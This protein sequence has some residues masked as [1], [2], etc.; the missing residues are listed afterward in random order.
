MKLLRIIIILALSLFCL[1]FCMCPAK[2]PYTNPTNKYIIALNPTDKYIDAVTDLDKIKR[3]IDKGEDM[4]ALDKG[5]GLAPLHAIV[6]FVNKNTIFA[7]QDLEN[8][9]KDE[10]DKKKDIVERYYHAA[11]LLLDNGANVNVTDKHGS[12][13]LNYCKDIRCAKFFLKYGAD[14]NI[15][16]PFHDATCS[17]A[18]DL[19]KLY[20]ASGADVNARS[21]EGRTLLFC[22]VGGKVTEI[23][24]KNGADVKVKDINGE[25]PLF[26]WKNS[27][28]AIELMIKNGADV[29]AKN[30]KGETALFQPFLKPERVRLFVKYKINVNEQDNT[31]KTVLHHILS[32]EYPYPCDKLVLELLKNGAKVDIKDKVGKTSLD[33]ASELSN[34]SDYF[35]NLYEL[36]FKYKDR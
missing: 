15:G 10:I 34:K 12:T 25:T 3:L 20:I 30:I 2:N 23:L 22:G 29:N 31:G 13:A 9:T 27:D 36:I 33:I 14:I 7:K 24:I 11:E 21:P 18:T 35:K 8:Y 4:N 5:S 19:V 28:S 32:K 6:E 26:H 16:S 17:Y 1:Q